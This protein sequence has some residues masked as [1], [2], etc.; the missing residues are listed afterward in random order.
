M[1]RRPIHRGLCESS[2]CSFK[3]GFVRRDNID[4]NLF[5]LNFLKKIRSHARCIIVYFNPL[6]P[7]NERPK[8]FGNILEAIGMTPMVKL[9]NIPKSMGIKCQMCKQR[10]FVRK[11]IL[12]HATFTRSNRCEMRIPKSRWI[13]QGQNRSSHGRRRRR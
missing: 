9:N 5:S 6:S 11:T 7:S 1:T 12:A 4:K 3:S 8:V 13:R 2:S 10:L